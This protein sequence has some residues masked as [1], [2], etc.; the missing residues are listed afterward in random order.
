MSENRKMILNEEFETQFYFKVVK[1]KTTFIQFC[2]IKNKGL[3]SY[4]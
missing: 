4:R 2:F 3:L 1:I